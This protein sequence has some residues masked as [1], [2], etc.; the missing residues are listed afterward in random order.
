MLVYG[1]IFSLYLAF[2]LFVL[3]ALCHLVAPTNA[4]LLA[5][6]RVGGIVYYL[7]VC[8]LTFSPIPHLVEHL[9]NSKPWG[10]YAML[11]T[12]LGNGQSFQTV[13][14]LALWIVVPVSWLAARN[15]RRNLPYD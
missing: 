13:L 11:W 2:W 7:A 12:G 6:V 9:H 15:A 4:P 1:F 8:L 10:R 3:W 14:V 5:A